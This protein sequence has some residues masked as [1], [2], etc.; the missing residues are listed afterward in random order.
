MHA[1]AL[2]VWNR[3]QVKK[4]EGLAS[5]LHAVVAVLQHPL[6]VRRR[7]LRPV[8]RTLSLKPPWCTNTHL[9]ETNREM[10]KKQRTQSEE[11]GRA[12]IMRC[13]PASCAASETGLMPVR[14]IIAVRGR[15]PDSERWSCCSPFG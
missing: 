9:N 4:N 15:R 3:S 10:A 7:Q 8:A 14:T 1:A 11:F 13:R 2:S 6:R 5:D 12:Y